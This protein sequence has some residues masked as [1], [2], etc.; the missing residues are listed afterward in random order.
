MKITCLIVSLWGTPASWRADILMRNRFAET[1]SWSAVNSKIYQAVAAHIEG[2]YFVIDLC[3][4]HIGKLCSSSIFFWFGFVWILRD[5]SVRLSEQLMQIT[6][7]IMTQKHSKLSAHMFNRDLC[8]FFF[9]GGSI[10]ISRIHV[11][12]SINIIS[13]WRRSWL[14]NDWNTRILAFSV[15]L[16]LSLSLF[17][18]LSVWLAMQQRSVLTV[19]ARKYG[20]NASEEM[21]ACTFPL[22]RLAP[23]SHNS[24]QINTIYQF[25]MF[26]F[27]HTYHSFFCTNN[28]FIVPL[29]CSDYR[30]R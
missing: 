26:S 16:S 20:L 4:F 28:F 7:W 2:S 22:L 5:K 15:S 12:V 14:D 25:N 3:M 13:N 18:Y 17:R 8:V 9:V 11:A 10:A 30:L 23:I 1:R 6:T 21:T 27:M 24:R 29:L 19:I